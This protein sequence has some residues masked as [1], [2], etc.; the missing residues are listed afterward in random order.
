[1]KPGIVAALAAAALFGVSTP[2]A[3]ILLGT[4]PPAM[5]AGL[6]YLGSGIGLGAWHLL[7]QRRRRADGVRSG[8][9]RF[10]GADW[11]RLGGAVAA[12]GVAGPLLL[13][14]GLSTTPA[15]TASLLLNLEAV[16]TVLLAWCIFHEHVDRRVAI[17]M[18]C[19]VAGGSLLSLGE[20]A[21]SVTTGAL[22]IV[23]ACFFWAVDNNLTR[24]IA[25]GDA[26]QIA[27]IKGLVAGSVNLTLAMLVVPGATLPPPTLMLAAAIV[28]LA[29]YGISLVLFVIALRHLGA[30]RTGG[31]FSL[32][33]FVGAALSL[34]L[35]GESAGWQFWLAGMLMGIGLWLHLS[36]RHA[37]PH[38]H[39]PMTHSH[40]HVHD[41]HHRHTREGGLDTSEPH[42]HEHRHEP[43]VHS[44]PHYP[45]IHHRHRH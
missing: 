20:G 2:L 35:P 43:M 7:L 3:K 10:S 42:T 8:S 11:R 33:P 45:D 26:V 38:E 17:G 14:I 16:L 27:A 23:A 41:E 32:A 1:M 18:G 31:Y 34:A 21:A 30:A 28:G 6:L 5:L 29:G 36:E 15:A 22:A 25:A 9:Q 12:G 39:E 19:I 24:T 4:I 37:H 40:P 13:M 44:H